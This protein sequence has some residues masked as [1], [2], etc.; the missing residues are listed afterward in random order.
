MSFAAH[1]SSHVTH[2]M[3]AI[4]AFMIV[5]TSVVFGIYLT[6][7]ERHRDMVVRTL[8]WYPVSLFFMG[9]MSV[10]RLF[11]TVTFIWVSARALDELVRASQ[12]EYGLARNA[13]LLGVIATTAHYIIMMTC[14]WQLTMLVLPIVATCMIPA[15]VLLT[16]GADRFIERASVMAF[17]VMLGGWSLGMIPLV[18]WLD[19][20]IGEHG[21][22]GLLMYLLAVTQLNDLFQ[23][24]WGKILGKRR[25]APNISPKKTWG[26]VIGGGVTMTTIGCFLGGYITD[27]GHLLGF[28]IAVFL[29]AGGVLGDLVLSA[30]KRQLGVKDFRSLL[31]GFG[32]LLDRLDSM[33]L[34]GPAF[35]AILIIFYTQTT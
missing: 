11:F 34:N 25:F 15:S 12:R 14:S 35:V 27:F 5:G 31:P 9:G 1:L 16:T 8:S 32:G 26:G 23:Y 18:A 19:I 29:C 17:W 30:I 22:V 21:W 3:G 6:N 33:V 2:V 24:V 7:K 20:G 4:V 13:L 28:I 10:N